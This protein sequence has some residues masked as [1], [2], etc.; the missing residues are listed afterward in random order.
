MTWEPTLATFSSWFYIIIRIILSYL[1]LSIITYTHANQVPFNA[2][3]IIS[4]IKSFII[5]QQTCDGDI[6][7]SCHTSMPTKKTN[8]H[9]NKPINL[10]LSARLKRTGHFIYF[11]CNQSVMH[12]LQR[13]ARVFRQQSCGNASRVTEQTLG[14][15]PGFCAKRGTTLQLLFIYSTSNAFC[16]SIRR[17]NLIQLRFSTLSQ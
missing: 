9:N 5:K 12:F 2:G 7:V 14:D 16:A 17:P 10:L 8:K 4:M 3:H 6:T 11:C 15:F 13:F 1:K